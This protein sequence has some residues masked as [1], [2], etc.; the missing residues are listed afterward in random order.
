MNVRIIVDNLG[1]DRTPG[2]RDVREHDVKVLHAVRDEIRHRLASA[3]GAGLILR[4]PEAIYRRFSDLEGQPGIEVEHV[5][6]LRLLRERLGGHPPPP[7][8]TLELATRLGLLR[9]D[10]PEPRATDD[11]VECLLSVIAPGLIA[12]DQLN[13]LVIALSRQQVAFSELLGIP[14]VGTWL[15]DRLANLG[16]EDQAIALLD[17]FADDLAEGYRELAR[18]VLRERLDRFILDHSLGTELALPPRTCP[19]SLSGA[20]GPLPIEPRHAGPYPDFLLKLLDVADREIRGG[21]MQATAL[22]DLVLQDWPEFFERMQTLFENNPG[23]ASERLIDALEA[24]AG[25]AASSLARRMREYLANTYCEQLPENAPIKQVLRWSESYFRYA[26]GAFERGGEPDEAVSTSFARWVGSQGNRILQSQADWRAVSTAVEHELGHGKVVVLCVVDALGALNK[27]LLEVA[28][29]KRIDPDLVGATHLLFAPLPTI[30]QIGKVAVMTGRN[31][32]EQSGDYERALR[33]RYAEYLE[34]DG[35]L[36]LVKNWTGSREPLLPGTRLLVH[37]ENRI[38]DDLHQSADFRQHRERVRTT[39]EQLA[40]QIG[41]W[42]LDARRSQREIAV[43]ITADHGA[44]KLSRIEAPLPGTTP[45]ERRI[46]AVSADID[47]CP[48]GFIHR[49][50]SQDGSGYLIPIDRAAYQAGQTMLHGGLTPE[51]VLIPFVRLGRGSRDAT[52]ALK[53]RATDGCGDAVRDGWHL[54]LQVENTSPEAF[55]NVQIRVLKPFTGKFEIQS[56]APFVEPAPFIMRIESAIEQ[57]GRMRIPF[58]LRYR[59]KSDGPYDSE[60]FELEIALAPH[61]VERDQASRDFDDAF[62]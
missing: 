18:S 23:I 4:M 10:M 5:L 15:R 16:L 17:V 2:A 11:A 34:G 1:I 42:L 44:T 24:I 62:E 54:S 19:A 51:E 8:L 48:D 56:I 61:L 26:I 12:A 7:W 29:N 20:L 28:L 35:A 40:A 14:D 38:D 47:S 55:I 53:L 52:G 58:E 31:A 49:C 13:G 60:R 59:T 43:F 21:E 3:G 30:T 27:D 37:L 50:T 45:V 25:D 32:W 39:C 46:L 41:R 57:T 36:Q 9:E 22:A 6:P 33:D